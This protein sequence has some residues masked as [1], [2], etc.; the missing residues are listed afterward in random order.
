MKG[1]AL[2]VGADGLLGRSLVAR[3]ADLPEVTVRPV[4]RADGDLRLAD[5]WEGLPPADHVFQLAARTFVPDS[6]DHPHQFVQDNIAITSNALEYCR[7]HGSNMIYASSYLYG[8]PDR[9]PIS[10]S[11]R[12]IIPNPYAL[13][14]RMCEE[15]VEH[16][17]RLF[18]FPA[19]VVRPFNIYGLRQDERFLLPSIIHQAI[20]ADKIKVMDLEPKRDYVFV[21]DVADAFVA[22]ADTPSDFE[23]YNVGSGESFSVGEV[24]AIVMQLVGR[25]LP[26]VSAAE[27]R[28]SEIMD[29]RADIAKAREHLGWEPKVTIEAGLRMLVD[30]VR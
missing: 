23:V 21:E 6:W 4:T 16:F 5:N 20:H 10:E 8:N 29:T 7:R 9:L 28:S 2:V 11:A 12:I 26:V 19:T 18:S 17:S 13:S 30:S 25:E 1:T 22:C 24:V 14:K 3:L 15:M 27:R